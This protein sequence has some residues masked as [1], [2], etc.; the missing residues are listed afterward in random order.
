M[1]D[2]IFSFI[3]QDGYENM[4][5]LI[6][7]I[8]DFDNV[9]IFKD[10]EIDGQN[11]EEYFSDLQKEFKDC[12]DEKSVYNTMKRCDAEEGIA[13]KEIKC[14]ERISKIREEFRKKLHLE[15]FDSKIHENAKANAY[16]YFL[17]MVGDNLRKSGKPNS[18]KF[19]GKDMAIL[20]QRANGF[21]K[22]F[23]SQNRKTKKKTLICID[24]IRNPYEATYFQD[25]YNAFYLVAI[26]TDIDERER[27]LNELGLE[28]GQ[29]RNLENKRNT[30][31]L[32]ETMFL[33]V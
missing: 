5:D 2:M 24:A 13:D 14:L 33:L 3:V 4:L 22:A 16:T 29:I 31:N 12:F 25:R 20:A 30:L 1:S 28:K 15:K 8:L 7:S 11:F 32:K 6:R 9:E 21:I 19:S 18:G 10:T 27:R 26:N 23:R 17:Q